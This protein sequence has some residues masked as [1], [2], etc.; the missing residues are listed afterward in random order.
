LILAGSNRLM[1]RNEIVMARNARRLGS[2]PHQNRP[3]QEPPSP[4]RIFATRF[5]EWLRRFPD[6]EPVYRLPET[7]LNELCRSRKGPLLIDR[8]AEEAF[9]AHCQ[10]VGDAVGFWDNRPIKYTWLSPPTP[11]RSFK[12]K[13]SDPWSLSKERA[14]D[15]YY[16]Q[17]VDGIHRSLGTAGWLRTEPAFLKQVE[18]IKSLWTA[19]PCAERPSFPLSRE[20]VIS[21]AASK[22]TMKSGASSLRVQMLEF[23]DRWELLEMA[24]WELP[25]PRTPVLSMPRALGVGQNEQAQSPIGIHVYVPLHYRVSDGDSLLTDIGEMQQS[26]ARSLGIDQSFAGLEHYELYATVFKILHL[27]NAIRSRF[28][29]KGIKLHGNTLFLEEAIAG[30]LDMSQDSIKTY[31]KW[32]SA[33]RRGHRGSVPAANPRNR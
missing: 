24:T 1:G 26:L 9:T 27:E 16:K 2:V 8:E 7:V 10:D 12:T 18:E 3:S 33:C 23:F 29:H 25:D 32:V 20:S 28:L 11:P 19:A 14:A 15:S 13:T 31:R 21:V 22:G 6:C 4:Q 17:V 30:G 5:Q